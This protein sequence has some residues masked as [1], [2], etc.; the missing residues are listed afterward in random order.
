MVVEQEACFVARWAEW[1]RV[2]KTAGSAAE[3]GMSGLE[4]RFVRVGLSERQGWRR[5]LFR[6]LVLS[7][8]HQRAGPLYLPQSPTYIH[9]PAD[10]PFPAIVPFTQT[11]A[12]HPH[13]S[14]SSS[15]L[16]NPRKRKISPFVVQY[17]Q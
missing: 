3:V 11:P 13:H 4:L 1:R 8:P 10:M 17:P 12:N 2:M 14:T 16:Q 6:H 7:M 9:H 15:H 5:D